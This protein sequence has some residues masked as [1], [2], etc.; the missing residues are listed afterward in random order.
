MIFFFPFRRLPLVP[1]S[2]EDADQPDGFPER[3]ERA[4]VHGRAVGAAAERSGQRERNTGVIHATEEGG[5]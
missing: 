4:A 1:L 3:Q 2:K 5:D